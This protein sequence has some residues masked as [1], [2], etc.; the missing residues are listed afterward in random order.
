M[1]NTM[2]SKIFLW[3]IL[4]L[5]FRSGFSQTP[6]MPAAR[7]HVKMEN[8]NGVKYTS[9]LT[10][11]VE[12]NFTFNQS[13]LEG[14][15]NI[16]AS[17]D[18]IAKLY[19][20]DGKDAFT[21]KRFTSSSDGNATGESV[22]FTLADLLSGEVIVNNN[23]SGLDLLP[24]KSPA[25]A[26]AFEQAVSVAGRGVL[27]FHA[28][29]DGDKGWKFYTE[30]LHPCEFKGQG[31]RVP[32]TVYKNPSQENHI[33]LQGILENNTT[34]ADVPIVIDQAG[35]EIISKRKTRQIRNQLFRFARNL[36]E[37]PVYKSL[38]TPLLKFDATNLRPD[39]E[40]SYIFK[41]GNMFTFILKVGNG[42]ASYIPSGHSDDELNIP[43]F[44]NGFS[45]PYTTFD[46]GV[47]DFDRYVAQTLFFLA[48]YKKEPCD[49]TNCNGLP[50]VGLNDSLTGNFYQTS[51]AIL[52]PNKM[53]FVS[54]F[55]KKYVAEV[56]DVMGRLVDVKKGFGRG[57]VAFDQG[58]LRP[59]IYFMSVTIGSAPAR[60][61]RYTLKK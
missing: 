1:E 47:G 32:V 43:L 10:Q 24:S 45:N 39:L 30:S 18:R 38:V 59:G 21:I 14:K 44:G 29:G 34:E 22:Q 51:T 52:D 40:S 2:H 25:E 58:K 28:S 26:T 13:H 5:S 17:L 36:P 9:K 53:A 20:V 41:G 27:G 54:N 6:T 19:S 46:G 61:Q 15:R 8:G 37:D 48:G 33:I 3:I 4:I 50:I 31:P 56:S 42:K 49:R 11:V 7:V 35:F 55:N 23:I 12:L 60:I 57:T 16:T